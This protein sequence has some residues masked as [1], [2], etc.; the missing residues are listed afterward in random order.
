M[1]ADRGAGVVVAGVVPWR[2]EH[3]VDGTGVAH[4]LPDEGQVDERPEA[5]V[6]RVEAEWD[7]AGL[8]ARAGSPGA[9]FVFGVSGRGVRLA[10]KLVPV[11]AEDQV[12]RRPR[13]DV[14]QYPAQ[15]GG[16]EVV[17]DVALQRIGAVAAG[18]P[19]QVLQRLAAAAVDDEAHRSGPDVPAEGLHGRAVAQVAQLRPFLGLDFLRRS[20]RDVLAVGEPDQQPAV[21]RR[22]GEPVPCARNGLG[23]VGGGASGRDRADVV[24][25]GQEGGGHAVGSDPVLMP[26]VVRVEA[27]DG[28]S[29]V[30]VLELTAQ[31]VQ[32]QDCVL[33]AIDPDVVGIVGAEAARDVQQHEHV[34]AYPALVAGRRALVY[35]PHARLGG[36]LGQGCQP[37]RCGCDERGR[38]GSRGEVP[39]G[40]HGEASPSAASHAAPSAAENTTGR[41]SAAGHGRR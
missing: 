6:R 3:D 10:G 16:V 21:G 13:N 41:S 33:G 36:S 17:V 8:L 26:Q 30:C 5:F 22:L 1:A 2:T 28:D 4:A 14:V 18:L 20:E 23:V 35:D 31:A 29:D 9:H 27:V 12:L 37:R 7:Q 15:V 38:Q 39:D 24:D 25:P 34:D 40:R 32:H 19:V 11:L